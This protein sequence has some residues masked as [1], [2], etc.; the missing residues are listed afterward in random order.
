MVFKVPADENGLGA[1]RT[2]RALINGRVWAAGQA[3]VAVAILLHDPDQ[4]LELD[5]L[6]PW[7]LAS[8]DGDS[9]EYLHFF[10]LGASN[11][12]FFRT[13][14]EAR[15]S[16]RASDLRRTEIEEWLSRDE[17]AQR[18]GPTAY[19]N[20]W[21][22]ALSSVFDIDIDQLPGLLVFCPQDPSR[23]TTHTRPPI[24]TYIRVDH[25]NFRSI[26]KLCISRA[27]DLADEQCDESD[28]HSDLPGWQIAHLFD[29]LPDSILDPGRPAARERRSLPPHAM[30]GWAGLRMLQPVA[31]ESRTQSSS[32]LRHL[33]RWSQYADQDTLVVFRTAEALWRAAALDARHHPWDWSAVV[34]QLAKG[35][36]RL[37]AGSVIHAARRAHGIDLPRWY[38]LHDPDAEA[39]EG[40]FDLNSKRGTAG[41][42]AGRP[43][44]PWKGPTIG[45]AKQIYE[46]CKKS[47]HLDLQILRPME[48]QFLKLWQRV[49]EVRNPFVHETIARRED[50]LEMA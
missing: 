4:D 50:A 18:F 45:D 2:L 48:K 29:A 17:P 11:D 6:L 9:G 42:K 10:C 25:Q 12:S 24:L 5:E 34:G 33:E 31:R 16:P 23:S 39:T 35:F 3:P 26:V 1:L 36:E 44:V 28:F 38:R 22:L 8:I 15:R 40:R 30:V 47:G 37:I 27:K 21:R 41:G 13:D 46:L 49:A 43:L 20:S 14:R 19:E 32:L 7:H